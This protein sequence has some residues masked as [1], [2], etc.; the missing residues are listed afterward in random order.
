MKNHYRKEEK[1]EIAKKMLEDGISPEF[2]QK[3]TLLIRKKIQE[4]QS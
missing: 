1:I 4:L 2:V 3:Y